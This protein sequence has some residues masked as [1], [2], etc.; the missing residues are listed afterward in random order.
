MA[1]IFHN[2][3]VKIVL[4]DL[5]MSYRVCCRSPIIPAR[6]SYAELL[7]DNN[8]DIPGATNIWTNPNAAPSPV[9]A[10]SKVCSESEMYRVFQKIS[11]KLKENIEK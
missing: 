7:N 4:L 8:E 10:F 3:C 11:V 6:P 1:Y 9:Y 5:I 2:I